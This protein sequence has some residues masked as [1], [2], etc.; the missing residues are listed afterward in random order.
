MMIKQ[1]GWN[2]QLTETSGFDKMSFL[3][4]IYACISCGWKKT[5]TPSFWAN[6]VRSSNLLVMKLS[7][8]YEENITFHS[9]N[10]FFQ[11][12]PVPTCME[13]RVANSRF[14]WEKDPKWSTLLTCYS[15]IESRKIIMCGGMK[16]YRSAKAH[17]Q[18]WWLSSLICQNY[19]SSLLKKTKNW[20]E[21]V[22]SSMQNIQF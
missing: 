9:L 5:L 7:F 4:Y 19:I 18:V 11:S 17:I 21:F 10:I 14:S 6:W 3:N 1:D 13:E 2:S 12:C 22:P 15:A 8:T 20:M 16:S